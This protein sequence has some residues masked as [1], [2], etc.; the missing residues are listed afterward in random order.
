MQEVL[1]SILEGGEEE[2]KGEREGRKEGKN[3]KNP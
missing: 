1:G 2:R 3:K